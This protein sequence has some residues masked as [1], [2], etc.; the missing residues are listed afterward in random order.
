MSTSELRAAVRAL[1]WDPPVWVLGETVGMGDGRRTTF[2]LS[3]HPLSEGSLLVW[4]DVEDVTDDLTVDGIHGLLT[5]A[6]APTEG[7]LVTAN[8][9]W[10]QLSDAAIDSQLGAVD[11]SIDLAAARCLEVLQLD[12]SAVLSLRMD[13]IGVDLAAR[14]SVITEA[15]RTLRSRG[16]Y[17]QFQQ[18]IDV[19]DWGNT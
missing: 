18:R 17:G 2:Q 13:G 3:G 4:L 12:P 5:F 10:S 16:S 1:I 19:I 7:Q 6:E 11:E 9:A 15:I 8:Y 14:R